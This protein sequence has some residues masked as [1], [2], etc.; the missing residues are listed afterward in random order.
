MPPTLTNYLLPKATIKQLF[1][2]FSTPLN[3]LFL[4]HF[5]IT[6]LLNEKN[7]FPCYFFV[8][9]HSIIETVRK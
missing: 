7:N 5:P 2:T 4:F 8:F 3:F 9:L 1:S 6:K